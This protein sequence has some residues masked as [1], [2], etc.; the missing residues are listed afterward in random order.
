MVNF[1]MSMIKK[2]P[3]FVFMLVSYFLKNIYTIFK[4]GWFFFNDAKNVT[5]CNH[6]V[7]VHFSQHLEYTFLT[8][9]F[10]KVNEWR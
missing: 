7:K 5:W 1:W 6:Q 4:K 9:I 8:I 10:P 3:L 2:T